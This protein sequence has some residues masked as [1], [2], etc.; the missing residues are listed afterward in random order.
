LLTI[1]IGALFTTDEEATG[2][3]KRD[4]DDRMDGYKNGFRSA[5]TKI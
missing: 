3:P 1:H 5:V 4:K 2:D